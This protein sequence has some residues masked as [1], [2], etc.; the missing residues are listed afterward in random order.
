M[1]ILTFTW[2]ALIGWAP[3]F[4]RRAIEL[5]VMMVRWLLINY[6]LKVLVRH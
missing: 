4:I 6:S 1:L 5:G 3:H 2:C